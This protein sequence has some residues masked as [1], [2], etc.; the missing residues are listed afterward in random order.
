MS[1]SDKVC[2][3]SIAAAKARMVLDG[4]TTERSECGQWVLVKYEDRQPIKLT[5][6]EYETVYAMFEF[7]T[8]SKHVLHLSSNSTALEGIDAVTDKS[9]K[10][11]KGG[12]KKRKSNRKKVHADQMK[13]L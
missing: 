12:D 1:E 6:K 13:L 9:G 10:K 3:R 2:Y 7:D 8:K 5:D 11:I 4:S